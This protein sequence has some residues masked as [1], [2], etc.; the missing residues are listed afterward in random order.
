MGMAHAID[1]FDIHQDAG[2]F[3]C[4]FEFVK[5]GLKVIISSD[6]SAEI[7]STKCKDANHGEFCLIIFPARAE[8][9]IK[10]WDEKTTSLPSVLANFP[11][12]KKIIAL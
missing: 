11:L 8:T 5:L 7:P 1:G 12:W 4:A 10:A 9:M 2:F 6:A 3:V